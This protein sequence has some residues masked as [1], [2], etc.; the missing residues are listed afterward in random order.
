[1]EGSSGKKDQG[2]QIGIDLGGT[3]TEIILLSRGTRELFR[4]R[5]PTPKDEPDNYTAVLGNIQGLVKKALTCLPD[6]EKYT[7]GIGIP[8]T[9]DRPTRL[10]W[11][12]NTTWLAGKPFQADLEK[13]LGRP[14]VMDNDANC[15]VLAEA[16]AGAAKGFGLVFGIIMGT[17]CGGGLCIN[18]RLHS[19]SH[20][21]AGEWGHLSVDPAGELC[22]CG[23]RG[24]IDTKLTGPAMTRAYSKLTGQ[25]LDAREIAALARKG[26]KDGVRVFQQFLDDFGRAV[27]GLIS[28]LDPDAIVLGG[29]LSNI[30]ELYSLG[31][32]R[33]RAYAFHEKVRTPILKNRLGDSAG[34]IGAA[35][36]GASA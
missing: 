2:F 10:V 19:G 25:T 17:G 9:L 11:N 21:I 29:G 24:C 12:A 35:W 27:G 34:V 7:I 30:P 26:E 15:F 18:G 23:N 32:E 8:G 28:L 22:F 1:M 16:M 3:K 5:I 4:E 33:V 13:R 36:L 31:M 6:R 20:G 14:V